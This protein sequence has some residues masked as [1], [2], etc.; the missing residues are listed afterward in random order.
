M[1]L[2]KITNKK[3]ACLGGIN[4]NNIK[5]LKMLKLN[6]IAGI[7]LFNNNNFLKIT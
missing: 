5:R 1:N 7:K 2:M 6:A 3:I 4:I